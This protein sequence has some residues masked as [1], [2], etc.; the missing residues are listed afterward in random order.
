MFTVIQYTMAAAAAAELALIDAVAKKDIARVELLLS[1]GF[2]TDCEDDD[3]WT[4]LHHAVRAGSVECINALLDAGADLNTDDD[5]HGRFLIWLAVKRG[6]AECVQ[7]L[8]DRGVDINAVDEESGMTLL[9][10][11]VYSGHPD[12]ISTLL[13]AGA[14]T[15]ARVLT[16][17]GRPAER[18]DD[19]RGF[20]ALHIAAA[21]TSLRQSVCAA[22]ASALIAGGADAA[23]K[24][25]PAGTLAGDDYEHPMNGH[26]ALHIV[27]MSPD[28]RSDV[29]LAILPRRNPG[30]ANALDSNGFAPMH[31]AADAGN[32]NCVRAL[33]RGGANIKLRGGYDRLT[34][35]ELAKTPLCAEFIRQLTEHPSRA[36]F[37]GPD[38]L[39]Y[40]D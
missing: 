20:T 25:D 14:C 39:P 26:T 35:A 16:C 10:E 37:D 22:C 31:V 7:L 21:H 34:A 28:D 8:V 36:F 11:A 19:L 18:F 29:I 3:G 5:D 9:H 15:S 38:G 24:V 30:L 4:A 23:A 12:R 2:P 27:A 32:V 13:A 6:H 1:K 33:F 17:G 40:I